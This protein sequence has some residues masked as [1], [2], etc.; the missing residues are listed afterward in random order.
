MVNELRY[1]EKSDIWAV[2]CV[3]YELAA[4]VYVCAPPPPAAPA[5]VH[6]GG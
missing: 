4:L 3:V 2:G 6:E 1:N 5:G